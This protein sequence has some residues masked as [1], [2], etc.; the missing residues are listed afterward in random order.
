[1]TWT[2]PRLSAQDPRRRHSVFW[3]QPDPPLSLTYPTRAE[4]V[5]A[6]EAADRPPKLTAIRLIRLTLPFL[7][8]SL[9]ELLYETLRACKQMTNTN[10]QNS[11]GVEFNPA[12][13]VTNEQTLPSVP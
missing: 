8:R 10:V 11:S 13:L 5:A 1:M 9:T 6:R 2:V 7:S 12:T 4:Y 3:A